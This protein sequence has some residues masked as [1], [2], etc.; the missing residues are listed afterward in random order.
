MARSLPE[1]PRSHTPRVVDPHDACP[2]WHTDRLS[3]PRFTKGTPGARTLPASGPLNRAPLATILAPRSLTLPPPLHPHC[4]RLGLPRR[5]SSSLPRV[6][7]AARAEKEKPTE[8][9]LPPWC[10]QPRAPASIVALFVGRAPVG[11]G[12]VGPAPTITA[13]RH[14]HRRRRELLHRA[15][16][17][18]GGREPLPPACGLP[19]QTRLAAAAEKEKPTE[20]GLNVCH[21]SQHPSP[22]CSS[23]DECEEHWGRA[24]PISGRS[25][26]PGRLRPAASAR[27]AY[28]LRACAVRPASPSGLLRSPSVRR[29]RH[30]L[31]QRCSILPR[32]RCDARND[33]T[34]APAS[35][36]RPLRRHAGAVWRWSPQ[37]HLEGSTS[38]LPT[39]SPLVSEPSSNS[40]SGCD[41]EYVS[42]LLLVDPYL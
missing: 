14:G 17:L 26:A 32:C 11:V 35:L 13:T 3:L 18:A 40:P 39:R 1:L 28:E 27:Y 4:P 24:V 42:S 33:E 25:L 5:L 22:A 38:P 21:G 29:R 6:A 20:R 41:L 36:L 7:A 23:A 30:G 8:R 31:L 2:V 9:G 19:A 16:A 10:L 37:P 15:C 12:V 34:S